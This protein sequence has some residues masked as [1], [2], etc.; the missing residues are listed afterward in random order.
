MEG[1][2]RPIYNE[3]FEKV[4]SI[5]GKESNYYIL[6]SKYSSQEDIIEFLIEAR[7]NGTL[8]HVDENQNTNHDPRLICSMGVK[9]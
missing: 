2:Y 3:N 6:L 7:Q 5:N 8:C 9:A 1:L 4:S